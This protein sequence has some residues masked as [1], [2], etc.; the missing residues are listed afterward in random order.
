MKTQHRWQA[1]AVLLLLAIPAETR[2]EE[3]VFGEPHAEPAPIEPAADSSKAPRSDA[4]PGELGAQ[5]S[6]PTVGF[7]RR[8]SVSWDLDLQGGL[9]P[10]FEQGGPTL[11][12]FARVRGGA[13]WMDATDVAAPNFYSLGFFADASNLPTQVAYGVQGE[14]MSLSSGV[15]LQ[16]GAGIDVAAKPLFLGSVGWSIVGVEVQARWSEQSDVFPVVF[17][18]L[19]IPI[20]VIALAGR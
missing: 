20:G 13:I 3:S 19:R 7:R 5:F 11:A 15:W 16:A 9:G 2:A 6:V 14:F 8:S 17:G 10:S 18:K 12:G 4:P 1:A